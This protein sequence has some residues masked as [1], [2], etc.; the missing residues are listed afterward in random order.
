VDEN[1]R[2]RCL[3]K[4]GYQPVPADAA[5]FLIRSTK[6]EY[7]FAP[8]WGCEGL[9]LR[10]ASGEVQPLFEVAAPDARRVLADGGSLIR[11]DELPGAPQ[12]P[13]SLVRS[14]DNARRE[15][16]ADLGC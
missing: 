2:V 14:W 3:L 15:E 7:P 11:F 4:E 9:F 13:A 12:A 10:S 5:D 6:A 1:E 16:L 8:G